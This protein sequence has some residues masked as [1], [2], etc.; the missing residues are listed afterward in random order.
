MSA[1][2]ISDELVRQVSEE[3]HERYGLNDA[4]VRELGAK[5]AEGRLLRRAENT[6]FAEQFTDRHR[7][8]FDRLAK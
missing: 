8:T 7:E 2:G 4:D 5:L 3:L 6:T 1:R